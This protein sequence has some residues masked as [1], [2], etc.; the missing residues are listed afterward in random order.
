VLA[1]DRRIGYA[2]EVDGSGKL[3]E[4]RMQGRR[5]MPQEV[6]E[7]YTGMWTAIIREVSNQMEKHPPSKAELGAY[8]T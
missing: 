1:Q 6:I 5:L 3:I 7:E 4:S 2:M 8:G